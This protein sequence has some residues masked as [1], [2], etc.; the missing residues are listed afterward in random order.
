MKLLEINNNWSHSLIILK[1][2]LVVL[3]KTIGQNDLVESY[4]IL[5][6]LEM[7][8]MVDVLK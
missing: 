7:T 4:D 3:S 1:S 5:F 6:G 2:L 8:I